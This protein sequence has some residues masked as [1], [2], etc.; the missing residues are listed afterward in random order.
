MITRLELKRQLVHLSAGLMLVAGLWLDLI[1]E[2][3]MLV[4]FF[5][6][7][8]LTLLIS[9]F[10]VPF[11]TSLFNN[12]ERDY[13]KKG[14]RGKGF[15]FYLLGTT[16]AVILFPKDVSMAAIAILALG[17]SV[18]RLVGPY[19]YLKHP[20]NSKKFIE[21]VVA[22]G[23]AAALAAMLFVPPFYAISA[24]AVAMAIESLDIKINSNKVDD[25]LTIPLVSGIVMEILIVLL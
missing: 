2:T 14:L 5:S 25:N 8:L 9:R 20:W 19:G 7:L 13:E 23:V 18:S 21:G 22:G 3:L 11:F 4:A 12:L 16:L 10:H 15:L 1:T 24:S 6:G 17:D